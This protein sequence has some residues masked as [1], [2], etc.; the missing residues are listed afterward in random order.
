MNFFLFEVYLLVILV[1]ISIFYNSITCY[2]CTRMFLYIFKNYGSIVIIITY[3]FILCFISFFC[4]S[5]LFD[6]FLFCE[7]E[8]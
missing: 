1:V 2:L 8:F 5:M 6:N 7:I 3:L 4:F